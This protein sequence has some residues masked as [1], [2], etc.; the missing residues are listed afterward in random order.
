MD[1]LLI[2][3]QIQLSMEIITIKNRNIT[4]NFRIIKRK[5]KCHKTFM[6]K[7]KIGR[8]HV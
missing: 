2:A 5:P 4:I 3:K 6:G 8:A 7:H 1:Q